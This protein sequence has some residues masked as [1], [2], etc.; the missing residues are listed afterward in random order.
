MLFDK[1]TALQ[2]NKNKKRRH[3]F[4][5]QKK[6]SGI[7]VVFDREWSEKFANGTKED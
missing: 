4:K 2:K 3:I 7:E 6:S 1:V 5:K